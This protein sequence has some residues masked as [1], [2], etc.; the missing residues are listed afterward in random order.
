MSQALR[1]PAL[2]T[3]AALLM[4]LAA[5][6][7]TPLATLPPEPVA[8][9]RIPPLPEAARQ[10]P[11]PALCS[12]SCSKGLSTLLESWQRLLTSPVLPETPVVPTSTR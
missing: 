6:C 11:A 12:P 9:A 7:S 8:P 1:A 4:L 3:T 10:P 5:G 2:M